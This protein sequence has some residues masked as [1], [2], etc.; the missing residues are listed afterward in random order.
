MIG[1]KAKGL[2]G[3]TQKPATCKTPK[4]NSETHGIAQYGMPFADRH[5]EG[6]KLKKTSIPLQKSPR[7]D[8]RA[9]AGESN[10]RN[11]VIR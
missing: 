5:N 9:C 3:Q 6:G 2:L 11:A 1:K 10:A 7:R 8:C 4:D